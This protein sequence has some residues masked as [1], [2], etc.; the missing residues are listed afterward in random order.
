MQ[1][2]GQLDLLD[3]AIQTSPAVVRRREL[4]AERWNTDPLHR[5]FPEF[6][7]LCGRCGEI[8][9]TFAGHDGG[10]TGCPIGSDPTWKRYPR[11][12]DGH[13]SRGHGITGYGEGILRDEDLCDRWDARW[14]P[15]CEC[16]H[17]WGVHVR[18]IGMSDPTPEQPFRCGTYC[19]CSDYRD[20][21]RPDGEGR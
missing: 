11:R 18:Q 1:T 15:D 9:H 10:Y 7:R 6:H 4:L 5:V 3:Y 2:A 21:A 12:A 19:G 8:V 16:G 14:W 13:G 17:A 20:A